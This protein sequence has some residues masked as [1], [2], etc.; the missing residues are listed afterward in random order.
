MILN[1]ERAVKGQGKVN[2]QLITTVPRNQKN[3]QNK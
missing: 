2:V 3:V 1:T